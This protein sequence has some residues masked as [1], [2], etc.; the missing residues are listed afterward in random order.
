MLNDNTQ[1][2]ILGF[3]GYM[4]KGNTYIFATVLCLI[5]ENVYGHP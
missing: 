5:A 4:T 2:Y 3:K 1:K